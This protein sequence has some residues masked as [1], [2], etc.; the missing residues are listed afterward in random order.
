MLRATQLVEDY[1]P[2]IRR[3][4]LTSIRTSFPTFF[5]SED[6]TCLISMNESQR[7]IYENFTKINQIIDI[8]DDHIRRRIE[9]Y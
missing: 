5:S 1:H 7:I 2:V 3:R 6:E 8:V 4:A 9:C